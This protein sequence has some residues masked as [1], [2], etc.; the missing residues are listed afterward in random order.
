MYVMLDTAVSVI[1]CFSLVTG[2]LISFTHMTVIII[3]FDSILILVFFLFTYRPLVGCPTQG[4]K[5]QYCPGNPGQ[6][7]QLNSGIGI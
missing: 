2:V 7:W 6:P 3:A 4:L 1:E 5:P